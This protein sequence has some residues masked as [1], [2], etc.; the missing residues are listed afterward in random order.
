[1]ANTIITGAFNEPANARAALDELYQRQVRPES[2]SVILPEAAR[3]E[4]MRVQANNKAPEGLVVGGVTGVALGG[5][6]AGLSTIALIP[7]VGL[8]A[9]GPILAILAGAGAGGALGGA[10]GGLVGLGITE[11][12]AN[13]H[14]GV[15]KRGGMLILVSSDNPVERRIAKEVFERRA[16]KVETER[17]SFAHA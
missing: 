3:E 1:M 6:A 2:V 16:M 9:A 14:E 15:L 13:F 10:V 8:L 4:F 12:D 17:A 5:L 7:G 11:H